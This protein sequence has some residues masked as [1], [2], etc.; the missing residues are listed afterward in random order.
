MFP[1]HLSTA[2]IK[3]PA[4]RG[5]GLAEPPAVRGERVTIREATAADMPALARVAA[6]DSAQ[7][8]GGDLLLAELDGRVVAALSLDGGR[9]IAD[10]FL[11][12]GQLIGLL[13]L[14]ARQLAEAR[15]SRGRTSRALARP[16]RALAR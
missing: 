8:P 10:P 12:T 4:R 1:S 15:R 2:Q 7:V 5:G 6:L 16:L 11:P 13:D 14:R 3:S 9:A